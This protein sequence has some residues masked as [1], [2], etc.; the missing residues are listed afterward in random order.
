[1]LPGHF[2]P[3]VG[4]LLANHGVQDSILVRGV[5]PGETTFHAGVATIGLAVFPGRHA[6]DL[7]A[8]HFG[9]EATTHAA[10]S[11]GGDD[12]VFGLTQVDYRFLHQRR[13]GAGLD[14]G[15]AGDAVTAQKI[16]ILAGSDAR[17][18]AALVYGQ[19]ESALYF[20][21]GT[22]AAIADNAFAGV[23]GKVRIGV[24]GGVVQM[25]G[26]VKAVAHAAQAYDAGHVLQLAIAVG[27]TG[28]AVQR[29]IGDVQ[30]HHVAAQ[31]VQGVV[32]GL[33]DHAFF[34]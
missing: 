26:A 5:T 13:R 2:L 28:Q 15:T 6:N 31:L 12:G 24:V 18:K 19:R 33:H 32:F 9:L 34:H 8:L 21:T 4:D 30:L 11:A 29:V 3:G 14:A 16:I 1:L 27:R 7:V 23:I 20:L 22:Y 25:V 10:V 17:L